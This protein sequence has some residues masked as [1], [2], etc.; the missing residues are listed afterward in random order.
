MLII[1]DTGISLYSP[2]GV[3]HNFKLEVEVY[4]SLPS[5]DNSG[6]VSTPIKMLKKLRQK[7]TKRFL[8]TSSEFT[9]KIVLS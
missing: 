9:C 2:E 6:K 4:C 3:D 7:V 8:M 5:D 1:N